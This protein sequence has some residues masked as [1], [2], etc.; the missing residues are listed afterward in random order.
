MKRRMGRKSLRLQGY[1]Y[2][3]PGPYFVTICVHNRRQ[4][5][6]AVVGGEMVLN[7]AGKMVHRMWLEQANRFPGIHLDEFVVMPD[8]MHCLL[9]LPEIPA[10]KRVPIPSTLNRFSSE[11]PPLGQ[12][13]GAFKSVTTVAYV[14]GVHTQGWPRF[15]TR[16]WQRNYHEWCVRDERANR[17]IQAYIRDNPKNWG[18]PKKRR[19]T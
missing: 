4:I 16:L 11:R 2:S 14:E 8:H 5:F 15:Q 13:V 1:D 10:D 3:Q 7:D 9:T 19:K 12:V 6:G 18:K 17:R